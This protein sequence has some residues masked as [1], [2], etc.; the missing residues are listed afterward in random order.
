M[1]PTV[2]EINKNWIIRYRR[3]DE[4]KGW[5]KLIGAGQYERLFGTHYMEKHF[6]KAME[7]G[8]DRIEFKIRGLYAI[9]FVGR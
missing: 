9:T 8:E 6:V 3:A 5:N 7:S 1:V 2:A 4:Q